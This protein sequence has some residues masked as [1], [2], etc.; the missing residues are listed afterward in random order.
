MSVN[1]TKISSSMQWIS[2]FDSKRL[3]MDDGKVK[4]CNAPSQNSD[5]SRKSSI[6]VKKKSTSGK[7]K[8]SNSTERF[9]NFSLLLKD[10]HQ[11]LKV[12]FFIN[13]F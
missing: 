12:S 7:F 10:Y 2:N 9:L 8:L 4:C 6:L 11:E 1:E 5:A 3:K 13:F